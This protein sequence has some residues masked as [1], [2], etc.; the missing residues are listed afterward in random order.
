MYL[1]YQIA[2]LFN[3]VILKCKEY[4]NLKCLLKTFHCNVFDHSTIN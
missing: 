3:F 2:I 4:I 1:E